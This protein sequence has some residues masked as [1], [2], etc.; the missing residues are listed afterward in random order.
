M[1]GPG[2]APPP[3]PH[4]GHKHDFG[5]VGIIGGC[6]EPDVMLGA[7]VLAGRSALRAGSGGVVLMV[8]ECLVQAALTMLP[9][10][11]GMP[12]GIEGMMALCVDA[13]VV[14]PGLGLG[15]ETRAIVQHVLG[16]SGASAVVDADALNTIATMADDPW[17]ASRQTV[18]TPHPGEYAR[19]AK[20]LGLPNSGTG[21]KER[22]NAAI[23]LAK[24]TGAVVVLKGFQTVVASPDDGV[25]TCAT[26]GNT[27]A[28][29]G[30]G[31]VLA[32]LLGAMIAARTRQGE[33]GVFDA[34]KLA[35]HIHGLAGDRYAATVAR[36][37]MLARELADQIPAI[38][39]QEALA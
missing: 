6:A 28:V 39:D 22:H 10:A 15:S 27:L 36:R 3:R 37:G 35:V 34:A 5:R 8:P 29:P 7:P 25:W 30:S 31:D 9:E 2:V 23:A 21:R 26:G 18:L 12:L 13:M 19:L 4:D 38:L 32:G 24:R 17:P 1:T 20:R 11:T 14:G 33:L 16:T